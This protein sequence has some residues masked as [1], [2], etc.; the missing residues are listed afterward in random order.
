[1][2]MRF[3]LLDLVGD[4]RQR[5][6]TVDQNL[7]SIPRPRRRVARSKAPQRRVESAKPADP[8]EPPAVMRNDESLDRMAHRI[9]Q[10]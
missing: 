9:V 5:R 1:M 4:P 6:R 3:G 8:R 7:E 2:H 10:S